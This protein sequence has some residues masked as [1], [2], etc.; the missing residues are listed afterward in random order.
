MAVSNLHQM[1]SILTLTRTSDG[2]N[3]DRR[4]NLFDLLSEPA[5]NAF[6]RAA[7]T[8]VLQDGQ[9]VYHQDEP[10]QEMFRIVSGEIRLFFHHPDGRQLLF[11]T[12]KSG[13]CFGLLSFLDGLPSQ[14]GAEAYGEV[15]LQVLGQRQY[16]M[17]RAQHPIF[18]DAVVELLCRHIRGLT[19]FVVDARLDDFTQSLA[20]RL[21]E[22]ARLD[23]DGRHVVHQS[24][25]ELSLL[26]GVSRQTINKT[27]KQ[28]EERGLVEVEYGAV[29]LTNI[30]GLRRARRRSMP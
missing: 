29:V 14:Y 24:Q 27:L 26:F 23:A 25:A 16:Q 6:S 2:R 15:T 8:R 9:V 10:G 28:F 1:E 19:T 20:R 17:L 3:R 13:E 4:F 30:K 22:S 5:Q 21:L 18:H 12:Y 7:K 11:T